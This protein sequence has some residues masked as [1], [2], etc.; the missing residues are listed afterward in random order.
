MGRRDDEEAAS[1]EDDILGT[2]LNCLYSRRPTG[3]SLSCHNSVVATAATERLAFSFP[4]VCHENDQTLVEYSFSGL[5]RKIM[6][7]TKR[8]KGY[9]NYCCK[10]LKAKIIFFDVQ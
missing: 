5:Q 2:V 7:E 8:K 1:I 9:N 3:L 10:L 4:R 6:N